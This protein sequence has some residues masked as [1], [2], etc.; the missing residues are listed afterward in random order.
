MSRWNSASRTALV[1][2]VGASLAI[3]CRKPAVNDEPDEDVTIA[4]DG[5]DATAAETDAQLITSSLVSASPGPIGL[6]TTDL[7]ESDLGTSDIG[8]GAKAI[9][10]PRTCL[11]VVA[12]SATRTATY[13]FDRC[14]GPNGLRGVTGEVKARYESSSGGLHLEL[15][16]TDLAVNRATMDWAATAD[17]TTS[18]ARRTMTWKAQLSG[19]TAR[20]RAFERTSEHTITWALGEACFGLEGSS[21]GTVNGRQI[22]TE[23]TGFRRC[24]REC[25]DAGGKIVVTNVTKNVRYELH[26]DG[27]NRATLIGPNGGEHSVP[28]LCSQ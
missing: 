14:M 18:D 3:G 28:L 26:Y 1:A 10:F 12:D 6:A 23:V 25:P 4:E 24:R 21:E 2:L 15:T 5:S 16:A 27:T 19:T 11:Q 20:G 13:T 9:Y 7:T 8:D 22:R 17:I